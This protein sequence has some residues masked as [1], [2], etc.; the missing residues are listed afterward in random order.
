MNMELM[1]YG[2]VAAEIETAEHASF[3]GI[4]GTKHACIQARISTEK[5]IE[6]YLD[7]KGIEWNSFYILSAR[8]INT[9]GEKTPYKA[10]ITFEVE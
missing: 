6:K 7:K 4:D 10:Y 8:S 9:E 1:V 2:V 5:T 3:Y